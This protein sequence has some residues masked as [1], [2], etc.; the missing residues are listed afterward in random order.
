[1]YCAKHKE[2]GHVDLNNKKCKQP[3][4]PFH[5]SFGPRG[6][7]AVYCAEH[8]SPE[9]V[10]LVTKRCSV[11]LTTGANPR[12]KEPAGNVDICARC[13]VYKHPDHKM[14]HAV[15]VKERLVADALR[16]ALPDMHIV[17]DK[18]VQ[19][20]C[21]GRRPD[22]FMYVTSEDDQTL[23]VL[24]I[25]CDE[26]QHKGY[27]CENK[28]TMQLF[29]DCGRVP[30]VLVRFNPDAYKDH[31]GVRHKSCFYHDKRG[32]PKVAPNKTDE[33][34]Q[35]LN[36]LLELAR[37]CKSIVPTKEVTIHHLFYDGYKQE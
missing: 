6:G 19:G 4:C 10:N 16:E 9:H 24:I 18:R 12:Y 26:D 27:S 31:A 37:A 1:M 34:K 15:R 29:E 25:E 11:C 35:R 32:M 30:I 21:S 36:T 2:G 20:G 13:F 8:C 33:W 23:Y 7:F 3:G 22:V 17:L 28:R 14:T 5:P